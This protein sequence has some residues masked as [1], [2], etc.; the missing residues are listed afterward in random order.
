MPNYICTIWMP[1]ETTVATIP[2]GGRVHDIAVSPD[3]EHV[4]VARCDA[5]M[6]VNGRQHIV[7]RIPVAGPVKNLVMKNVRI[8]ADT[9]LVFSD[10]QARLDDVKVT[11]AHGQA[12]DIRPTAK[13]TVH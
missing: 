11:A 7:A 10:A 4:Y 13:V 3:G 2:V 12:I 6:V 1:A 5:V 9:G 8:T